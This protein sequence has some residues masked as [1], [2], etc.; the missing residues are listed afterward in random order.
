MKKDK[1]DPPETMPERDIQ[2]NAL[3]RQKAEEQFIKKDTAK[4][5]PQAEGDILK[6]IHELEVHQIELEMQNEELRIA[7]EVAERITAKYTTLYDFAPAG[8][9]TI[10]YDGTIFEMNLTGAAMLGKERSVMVGI[11]FS[12]FVSSD[13]MA[14][15]NDFL[16][17]VFKTNEKQKCVVRLINNDKPS[18]Y[19]LLEGIVSENKNKCLISGIDITEQELTKQMLQ[20]SELVTDGFLNLQKMGY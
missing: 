1:M 19:I 9:F 18:S 3:L 11:S 17:Q 6:L 15:F 13:T 12:Q 10:N 7:K 8:Y 4:E 16:L 14:L 2:T 5:A 20:S